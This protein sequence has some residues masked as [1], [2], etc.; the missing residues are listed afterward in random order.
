MWCVFFS[1]CTFYYYLLLYMVRNKIRAG[2]NQ[3]HSIVNGKLHFFDK[4]E[5]YCFDYKTQ[6]ITAGCVTLLT[7]LKFQEE[8]IGELS[9]AFFQLEQLPFFSYGKSLDSTRWLRTNICERLHW[10]S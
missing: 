2:W 8:K 10:F 9:F 1:L 4:V 6:R 7:L 3:N 5:F